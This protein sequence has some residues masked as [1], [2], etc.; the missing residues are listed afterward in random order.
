MDWLDPQKFAHTTLHCSPGSP[1][2]PKR[3]G[4]TLLDEKPGY[5]GIYIRDENGGLWP[6]RT[7]SHK[8]KKHHASV[9]KVWMESP[10]DH[11][12]RR[13]FIA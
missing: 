13:H 9:I 2:V 6:A 11:E 10:G 4:I 8:P 5:T 1:G 7:V 12:D 3:A